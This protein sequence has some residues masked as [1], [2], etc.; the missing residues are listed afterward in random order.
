M[1][2]YAIYKIHCLETGKSYVGLTRIGI[3]KRFSNHIHN[4]NAGRDGALYAAIRKYGK[5]AFAVELLK[6]GLTLEEACEAEIALI[7]ELGTLVPNGYNVCTGGKGAVG[8]KPSDE[9]RARMSEAHKKRQA[10]PSLR[11]RTSMALQGKVKTPEH[12]AKIAAALK[13]RSPTE[14]TKAKLREANLGKKQSPETIK[15]RRQKMLGRKL[16]EHLCNR[17]G[18]WSRGKPKSEETRRKI[19]QAL[20]GKKR[21]PHSPEAIAKM[22]DAKRGRPRSEET[23]AKMR[24]TWA[25]KKE[26]KLCAC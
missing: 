10:N 2:D 18:D 17:L 14:E 26:E 15:K 22:S 20:K 8:F 4:A 3:H 21:G 16:P 12:L 11:Q 9:T 24:A 7:A 25:R 5:L 1:S 19:S 6:E 13:G 23:K